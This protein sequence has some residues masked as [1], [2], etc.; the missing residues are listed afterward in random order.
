MQQVANALSQIYEL[1]SSAVEILVG[2][3]GAARSAFRA[4]PVTLAS[5]ES[6]RLAVAQSTYFQVL[7]ASGTLSVAVD[8]GPRSTV[9]KGIGIEFDRPVQTHI[10]VINETGASITAT[11]ATGRGRIKDSRLT[12]AGGL[13]ISQS[14]TLDSVADVNAPN[15]ATTLILAADTTRRSFVIKNPSGGGSVRIGDAGAGAANGFELEAGAAFG[16][17]TGAA[18]YAYN[19]S[20]SAISLQVITTKD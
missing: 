4:I 11:I 17:E 19:G 20:G 6:I 10:E 13:D 15:A 12:V 3:L 7:E 8:D 18:V 9:S 2:R 5:G 16:L 14:A 1:L